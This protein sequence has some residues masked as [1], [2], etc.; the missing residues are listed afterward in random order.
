MQHNYKRLSYQPLQVVLAEWGITTS[1]LSPPPTATNIQIQPATQ[2][3][4]TIIVEE[5]CHTFDLTK[6]EF[7]K[8]CKIKSRKT[9]YNWING[10][11]SP[12]KSAMNR[13]FDLLI[14]I[15]EW[16]QA[17]LKCN[18]EQL[19]Y[20][21]LGQQSI[22]KMLQQDKID[23]ERIL[24]AGTRLNLLYSTKNIIIDPFSS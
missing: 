7:T 20:P 3:K 14:V 10:E 22:Y 12:R 4:F 13:I 23:K 17:D 6:E 9:L 8:I 2:S 19:H 18:K 15:R 24:F 16:E 5:I 1:I 21:I 11:A